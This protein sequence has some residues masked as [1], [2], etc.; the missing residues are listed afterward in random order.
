LVGDRHDHSIL[1]RAYPNNGE[2][3]CAIGVCTVPVPHGPDGCRTMIAILYRT[4]LFS[5][6]W[7]DG[8]WGGLCPSTTIKSTSVLQVLDGWTG[9]LDTILSAFAPNLHRPHAC[10]HP[11]LHAPSTNSFQPLITTSSA[12]TLTLRATH[13]PPSLPSF[14]TSSNAPILRIRPTP[15]IKRQA[16][17]VCS[18]LLE[19]SFHLPIALSR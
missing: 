13:T 10:H 1:L 4:E 8:G 7:M 14:L 11:V 3:T 2:Q 6:H 19:H 18:Q 15:L 16:V 5:T 17:S 9:I 12:R